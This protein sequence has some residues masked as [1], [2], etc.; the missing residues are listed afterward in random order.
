[1]VWVLVIATLSAAFFGLAPLLLPD[2]GGHFFGFKATD[3]FIFRQAGA[4]SLGYAVMGVFE[5]QSRRWLE[6]RLPV[7]MGTV[8]NGLAFLASLVAIATG[9][10]SLLVYLVAPVSLAVTVVLLVALRREG[11]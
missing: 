5:L 11:K 4:A 6:L 8:F 10:L 1:L 3:I 2:V 7:V 9:E